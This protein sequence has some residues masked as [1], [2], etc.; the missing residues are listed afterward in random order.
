MSERN[1]KVRVD[2]V[3]DIFTY[4]ELWHGSHSLL[5]DSKTREEGS[6]WTAMASLTLTAFSFEAYLNHLGDRMFRNWT[7]MESSS[8]LD[9]LSAIC[10]KLKV[11]VPMDMRPGQTVKSLIKFR[12]ALAH[13]KTQR[14]VAKPKLVSPDY[15]SRWSR[16]DRPLTEWERLCE[17]RYAGRA[18]DDIA[19]VIAIL[20]EASPIRREPLFAFGT[21]LRTASLQSDP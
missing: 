21:T 6:K 17:P 7:E 15:A 5:T 19:K 10:K 8:A 4:A 9:K 13:G 2:A 11:R 3:R 14:L 16:G 12:N 18:R 20:H 1:R